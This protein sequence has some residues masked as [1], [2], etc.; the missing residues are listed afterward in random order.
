MKIVFMGTPQFAVPSLKILLDKKHD[1]VGV[2]TQPDKPKG[3][4]RKIIPPPV[5]EVALKRGLLVLQPQKAR[6]EG[7]VQE[8]KALEPGAICVVSYGQLLP[9]DLLKI[10]EYG[11]I[12]VHTSLLPRYRGA[13]PMNWAVIN[14]ETV[15]GNTTML[16][17]SEMDAGDILLQEEAPIEPNDT[18]ETLSGKMAP[19]A[20]ELLARTLEG[21]E[22][23]RLTPIPQDH[24]A[25]TFAPKLTKEVAD[26]DWYKSCREIHNLVRGTNPWPGA[27]TRYQG[28]TIKIWKTAPVDEN[29]GPEPGT[30]IEIDKEG[31]LVQ[32]GKGRLRIEEVQ[33]E[34]R[35]RMPVNDFI[36][37]HVLE[38]GTRFK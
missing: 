19:M 13:A 10:P 36:Q 24:T 34:N 32:T 33:L 25:V 1:V 22:E 38:P 16:M 31:L 6:D 29:P 15:T 20:A 4:G 27:F 37:G 18:A 26:I 5:K 17:N 2:V 8:V 35:K 28:Q 9:D 14:G 3:R 23:G 11:A 21:I 7:F 12:N 30:I